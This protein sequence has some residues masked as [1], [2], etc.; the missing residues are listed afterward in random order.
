VL[1]WMSLIP[2]GA[3][4]N[5]LL[6]ILQIL[7]SIVT[8]SLYRESP[9]YKRKGLDTFHCFPCHLVFGGIAAYLAQLLLAVARAF[10]GF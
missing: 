7:G 3:P 9:L 8:H 1:L 5:L 2:C 10:I 4:S 6:S